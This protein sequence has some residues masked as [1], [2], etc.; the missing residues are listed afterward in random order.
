M[1][2]LTIADDGGE[3]SDEA[4]WVEEVVPTDA[5]DVV[6]TATSGDVSITDDTAECLSINLTGYVG[7][8]SVVEDAVLTVV[9]NA[10]LIGVI[11]NE[12]GSII[13]GGNLTANGIILMIGG[14]ITVTGDVNL[15]GSI[16]LDAT[17]T[18]TTS[19]DVVI[20]ATTVITGLGTLIC[21]V[22]ASIT[23]NAVVL[24][25][26]VTLGGTAQTFILADDLEINSLSIP[27]ST[28]V[29]GNQLI[30]NGDLIAGGNLAGTT[31]FLMAGTGTL[32]V[33]GTLANTIEI[34]SGN[35]VVTIVPPITVT[36]IGGRIMT[37]GLS[38]PGAGGRMSMGL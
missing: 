20:D 23:S 13:V 21:L 31:D 16:D 8:L 28:T 29:N 36:L 26:S 32:S 37:S 27:N 12:G 14:T 38:A 22:S 2:T 3:W 9:G 1:A 34:D 18:I 5:D 4:T 6:A 17:S 7:T 10:T 30:V 33:D 15:D 25:W 35:G 11:D 19:G 24:S